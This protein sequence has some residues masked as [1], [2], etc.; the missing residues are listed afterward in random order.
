MSE[1][2]LV[3]I[4]SELK[5]YNKLL[6][7]HIKRTDLLEKYIHDSDV[8]WKDIVSRLE[9]NQSRQQ[10]FT[11]KL[12]AGVGTFTGIVIPLMVKLLEVMK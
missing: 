9:A 6:A 10:S 2:R 3:A 5:Y 12:L 7:E 11:L 4:E 8:G 1:E